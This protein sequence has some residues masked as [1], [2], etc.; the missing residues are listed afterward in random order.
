MDDNDLSQYSTEELQRM[1]GEQEAPAPTGI[2]SIPEEELTRMAQETQPAEGDWRG[3][4]AAGLRGVRRSLPFGQDIGAAAEA[5]RKGVP[6]EEEK[7]AQ[8]ARD[9]E[10]EKQ[11]PKSTLAGEVGG[12]F[13]PGF[14]LAGPMAK[15]EQ[16]VA[17]RLAPKVGE[18]AAR[19][20]GAGAAGA[21]A[22]A[23][24]GFGEGV[25]PEERLKG[26]TSAAGIGALGG[27][28]LPAAGAAVKRSLNEAELAAQRL[29]IGAPRYVT[30][31]AALPKTTAAA[32]EAVPVTGGVI[33]RAAREGIEQLGEATERIPGVSPLVDRYE[34]GA[35]A[36]QA[37]TGWAG[38]RSENVVSKAYDAV[39]KYINPNVATPLSNTAS[40]VQQ[41]GSKNLL[42][43][44]PEE[45]AATKLLMDAVTNPEGL[46]YEGI[47]FLRTHVGQKMKD[48]LHTTGVE[49]T[50][51]KQLYGSLTKDLRD[52]V[53]K[54]GGQRGLSAFERANT[55]NAQVQAKRDQL[56][57]IVGAAGDTPPEAVF[58]KIYRMGTD[59]A[60]ANIELLR[61]ARTSIKGSDWEDVT[62]GIINTMGRDAEKAFSPDRFVTAYG[63]LSDRGKDLI[64]GAAGNPVRQA[65]EDVN[66]LSSK[67]AQA[68]K[69]RNVSKTA[70]VLLG[71]GALLGLATGATGIGG[72]AA[73]ILGTI[74]VAM[75]LA[76]PKTAKTVSNFIKK[77]SKF[78]YN[79]L[80]NAARLEARKPE[81]DRT[82]RA[83]GGKV[84]PAKK[85]SLMEK[86]ARKAFNDIALESRPL[87]DMPDE[88]IVKALDLA[89]D[90]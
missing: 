11:Y 31:E 41:I 37:L 32:L 14:G 23:I 57:K 85:L 9:I 44:L 56:Y 20:V 25:T 1:L 5:F 13:V 36:K 82:P 75:L 83:A 52:A 86:A 26:A 88:A 45:T 39:D 89:K 38:T 51:L 19:I 16:A 81:E 53:E 50:E 61:N 10:L 28:A 73:G 27:A 70:P 17:S 22:G 79:A 66:L 6:F 60:G 33:Q 68:A 55:L 64:F 42:A 7:R 34:A 62:S 72:T 8:V 67:Y 59:K 78:S 65:M 71:A 84:Y 74:P 40:T 77:P 15:S 43:H 4:V 12:F 2:E 90:K 48:A 46:T 30:S 54:A 21:G 58:D 29:G 76:S 49:Q 87:M 63:K 18:T 35:A 47:K 3:E 24:Q 80:L 69:S